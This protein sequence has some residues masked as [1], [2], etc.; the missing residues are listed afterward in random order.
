MYVFMI[1]HSNYTLQLSKSHLLSRLLSRLSQQR[2]TNS[3]QQKGSI[4]AQLKQVESGCST[5]NHSLT[6]SR[7]YAQDTATD[8]TIFDRQKNELLTSDDHD[9]DHDRGFDLSRSTV[10]LGS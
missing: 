3:S 1:Q 5:C 6:N 10:S 2:L 4:K 8:H 9:V 7:V